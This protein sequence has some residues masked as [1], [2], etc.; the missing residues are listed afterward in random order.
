[1][2]N[3]SRIINEPTA[4]VLAYGM[5]KQTDSGNK[6]QTVLV[7]D[8]GGGTFDVSIVDI[9]E[10]SYEVLA[11]YGDSYLGGDDFTMCIYRHMK[12]EIFRK[13]KIDIT[14]DV[15]KEKRLETACEKLKKSLSSPTSTSG[16]ISLESFLP[17]DEAFKSVLS[18]A[19]FEEICVDLF[20]KTIA[21]VDEAIENANLS[22]GDL[23]EVILVGGSTRI[24]K[25]REMLKN[26]FAKVNSKQFIHVKNNFQ[27]LE[28]CHSFN[29]YNIFFH[30]YN[31]Q[32]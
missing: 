26:H 23:D 30:S 11:T 4:A 25:I 1:M 31:L 3:F 2:V 8:L 32:T 7:F 16:C 29:I 15:R 22:K 14:G 28:K 17:D 27:Y 5:D 6:E 19:K 18:R 13:Y 12:K 10:D 21:G 9:F 24:P 20:K